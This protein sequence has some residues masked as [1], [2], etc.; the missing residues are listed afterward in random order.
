[1]R[2]CPSSATPPVLHALLLA[3]ALAVATGCSRS[4]G[5]SAGG[6]SRVRLNEIMAANNRNSGMAVADDGG[7]PVYSDWVEL[8]NP[9]TSAVS[10]AGYTL[11]DRRDNPDKFEF[12]PGT[13]I[14][15]QGYL[16]VFFFTEEGCTE[17][18]HER[19]IE[20]NDECDQ[21]VAEELA[22]CMQRCG[23]SD[24]G[25]DACEAAC[26]SRADLETTRCSNLTDA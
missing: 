22:R 24:A 18:A 1:M 21:S 2:K 8:Y 6:S 14:A 26:E 16:M 23:D 17:D 20:C 9:G 25:K 5:S 3:G 7:N 11:S 15:P 13:V 12:P 19:E 4:G 10:L